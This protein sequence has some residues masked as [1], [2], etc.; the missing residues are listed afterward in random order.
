MKTGEQGKNGE[1]EKAES[2]NKENMEWIVK[3]N[4]EWAALKV[5]TSRHTKCKYLR[6]VHFEYI[7]ACILETI[8]KHQHNSHWMN[9]KSELSEL[10]KSVYQIS[11]ALI[12][13]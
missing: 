13:P 10:S 1:A 9:A 8:F 2:P 4:D 12:P 3:E 11:L 7:Y 6:V 5:D